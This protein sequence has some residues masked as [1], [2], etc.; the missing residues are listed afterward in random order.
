[1]RQQVEVCLD[2]LMDFLARREGKSRWVEKTPYNAGHI[3]RILS[4]WPGA[5]MIHVVRDPRDVYASMVEI[6]KWSEPAVFAEHWC[7]T[8][9]LAR[10]W[11]STQG[12]GHPAYHELRYETARARAEA[13]MREVVV[14]L[15]EAWEPEIAK[16][17]GPAS[18]PRARAARDRQDELDAET[19]CHA[20]HRQPHRHLALAD[21]RGA[22]GACPSRIGAAWTWRAR[23]GP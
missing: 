23:A 21:R 9:G 12:G 19:A 4:A 1:M 5:K 10:D 7:N 15:G 6:G 13:T 14:F 16:I 8:V 20:A 17:R 11:L 2:R 3:D 22:L 18:R